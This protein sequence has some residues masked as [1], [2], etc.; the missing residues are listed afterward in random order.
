[1]TK[2]VLRLSAIQGPIA[3]VSLIVE[4][5]IAQTLQDSSRAE[6]IVAVVCLPKCKPMVSWLGIWGDHRL[7]RQQKHSPMCELCA[8]HYQLCR[9]ISLELKDVLAELDGHLESASM[10]KE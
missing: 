4:Y 2:S 7:Q 10:R 3:A 8:T 5:T 1:M 9:A 6:M